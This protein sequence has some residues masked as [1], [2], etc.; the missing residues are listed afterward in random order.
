MSTKLN[1]ESII[2]GS[3]EKGKLAESV[4]ESLNKA[5]AAMQSTDVETLLEDFVHKDDTINFAT[6]L[7]GVVE[8]TPEMFTYRPSAGDKSVRDESAVIRRIK[9]NTTVWGQLADIT[10]V[11]TTGAKYI[12]E[13]GDG[14][15]SIQK[16]L[17]KTGT[18]YCFIN[19]GMEYRI[20]NHKYLLCQEIE[21]SGIETSDDYCAVAAYDFTPY[22]RVNYE[23][24]GKYLYTKIVT[25]SD[26]ANFHFFYDAY[27]NAKLRASNIQCFDLTAIFG[28]GNEPET[29]EEFRQYYPDA[30]YPYCAPEIRSMRATGIETV[31]FNQWDE[32]WENGTFNT[33]TGENISNNQIRCK[34]LIRIFPNTYY[35]LS[36]GDKNLGIWAMFYDENLNILQPVNLNSS[37]SRNC[38]YISPSGDRNVFLTPENATWMKFY[39][40]AEYGSTTYKGDICINLSHSGVR[41]GEYAPYEK[42]T[43]LLPEIAKYFPD[44]MQGIGDMCDEIIDGLAIQRFGVVDLGSLTWQQ[45]TSSVLNYEY[46]NATLENLKESDGY[47]KYANAICSE[48]IQSPS[49]PINNRELL[50]ESFM[51]YYIK[52]NNTLYMRS[53]ETTLENFKNKVNGILLYY[54]LAKP[55]HTPIDEPLQLDYKVDDFGTEKMLSDAPSTPFKAD[56][57]YQFNAEGRIRDNS[58]NI[59]K[60]ENNIN[61]VQDKLDSKQDTLISGT[62]IKFINGESVLGEGNLVIDGNN[63]FVGNDLANEAQYLNTTIKQYGELIESKYVKSE[64]GIPASDLSEEVQ[65]SL[66]KAD[67]SVRLTTGGGDINPGYNGDKQFYIQKVDGVQT[68]KIEM[69]TSSDVK[70]GKYTGNNG[71]SPFVGADIVYDLY[72]DAYDLADSKYTKPEEGISITDLEEYVQEAISKAHASVSVSDIEYEVVAFTID[73]IDNCAISGD[74]RD[75][76]FTVD[77]EINSGNFRKGK[78]PLMIKKS[79]DSNALYPLTYTKSGNANLMNYSGTISCVVEGVTYE[80][81]ISYSNTTAT[82]FNIKRYYNQYVADFRIYDL[83]KIINEGISKSINTEKLYLAIQNNKNIVVYTN[84]FDPDYSKGMMNI[85]TGGIT[86]DDTD[87]KTFDC[88]INTHNGSW[89]LT[90]LVYDTSDPEGHIY[91]LKN[92]NVK[93]YYTQPYVLEF[94]VDDIVTM[95]ED[96]EGTIEYNSFALCTA[97]KNGR[98]VV[99]KHDDSTNSKVH[100]VIGSNDVVSSSSTKF[101]WYFIND[102]SIFRVLT[103]LS[104][105]PDQDIYEITYRDITEYSLPNLNGYASLIAKSELINYIN[106]KSIYRS[107]NNNSTSIY[108][109]YPVKPVASGSRALITPNEFWKLGSPSTPLSVDSE[110]YITITLG[111][112]ISGVVNEYI[113]E[114][115]TGA[116]T[117]ETPLPSLKFKLSDGS[118]CDIKWVSGDAPV[119]EENKTYQI[120]IINKLG[121]V[122][123]WDNV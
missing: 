38:L 116:D 107:S 102:N 16:D 90:N 81:N 55:I 21:V 26:S 100:T 83:E 39:I 93:F 11:S 60:L 41:N 8:A 86:N 87:I 4:Q 96:G 95:F 104:Q 112:E 43:L 42:N 91:S 120:S 118:D 18:P 40:P 122:L 58:R 10:K 103:F 73:D 59:E 25:K 30:Y 99:I 29:Y 119:L 9:G 69:I 98:S 37:V 66:G 3:I 50:D 76:Q 57:V 114:I 110:G 6:D 121:T 44:G 15:F 75:A 53:S 47:G 48:F 1:I 49:Y 68:L 56:I 22:S 77:N 97:F 5:D 64:T 61:N 71:N 12:M 101:A 14:W 84:E 80:F 113:F 23:L 27:G 79:A 20:P 36:I 123:S 82:I 74:V 65:T 7:T 46:F 32:E 117:D 13:T 52:G 115:Y 19:M 67:N 34:N 108:T 105:Q 54:E 109:Y 70:S 17:N 24:N 33:E 111:R 45:S 89:K 51:I 72:N 63:I 92:S 62:N 35:S 2:D 106:G 28:A 31:G 94:T 78:K 88:V 85:L